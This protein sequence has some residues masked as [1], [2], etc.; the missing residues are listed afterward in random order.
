MLAWREGEEEVWG[1]RRGSPR[2]QAVH[3]KERGQ[4]NLSIRLPTAVAQSQA[5]LIKL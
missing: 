4:P 1:G 2:S 3:G 5:K